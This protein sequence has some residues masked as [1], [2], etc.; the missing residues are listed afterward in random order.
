MQSVFWNWINLDGQPI[1]LEQ[2]LLYFTALALILPSLAL[3]PTA[4]GGVRIWSLEFVDM[5]ARRLFVEQVIPALRKFKDGYL[6]RQVGLGCDIAKGADLADLLVNLPEY[7]FRSNVSPVA[8]LG[9]SNVR[10][11]REQYGWKQC[12]NYEIVCDFANSWKH[13]SITR[14]GRTMHGIDDVEEAYAMCRYYDE[15][16]AYYC[17]HKLILLRLVGGGQID[18][19]RVLISAAKF[20]ADSLNAL[21]FTPAAP[22]Q[23]F[24]FGEFTSRHDAERLAPLTLHGIVGEPFK[25]VGK[26]FDFNHS[27][28]SW[29]D[30]KPATGFAYEMPFNVNVLPSPFNSET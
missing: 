8:A 24:D 19:R 4:H 15:Q 14:D 10:A 2:A 22:S 11:Y 20:W 28:N 23:L 25:Y 9:F 21:D 3:Q 1:E 27:T 18:L 6:D 5:N 29:V 16:G 17:G 30:V 7:I 12:G 13:H 26:G